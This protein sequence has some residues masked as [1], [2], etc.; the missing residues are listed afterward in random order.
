MSEPDPHHVYSRRCDARR[1]EAK[2]HLKRARR[3]SNTRLAVFGLGMV[4][5]WMVW[6]AKTLSAW[7]MVP[8]LV[9]F[10]FLMLLHDRTLQAVRR[11]QRGASLYEKG[12][13]RLEDRWAG[14]GNLGLQFL[15]ESHPYARDM[16]LFGAGSLFEL[17]CSTRTVWGAKTLAEWLLTPASLDA[18]RA[19]QAAVAELRPRLELREEIAVLD[20]DISSEVD[21][22]AL[23]RWAGSPPV[24][25][26]SWVPVVAFVLGVA[27]V[28]VIAGLL[29]STFGRLPVLVVLAVESGLAMWWRLRVREV[30]FS[31]ERPG[32]ELALLA[33]L[34]RR[35]ENEPFQSP[36][37]VEIQKS[38]ESEGVTASQQIARLGRLI[39]LLDARRNQLFAPLAALLMWGTQVAFALERWR[40]KSGAGVANILVS[41][42]ELEALLALATYSYEHPADPFP[43]LVEK[44]PLFEGEGLGHPLIPK[45]YLVRNDVRLGDGMHLLV[46]SGS[47]MS[48]K[49]TLLRTIGTNSVLA[50]C[51]APVRAKSLRMSRLAVGASIRLLDSLQEGVSRF[52]AEIKRLRQIMDLSKEPLPLVFLLDEILHGT[53]S[54][55]RRI[56]A[57]AVVR[58]LVERGAVGLITTHDL[59]LSRVAETLAAGAA[60]VHFE[61][62]LEDGKMVFDYRLR[63]GV[64]RKSNALDLM[65]S[66]GLEV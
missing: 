41:I 52:Y 49:S 33:K 56:G 58:G 45:K 19:R 42:G 2:R 11:A 8:A 40:R 22:D 38:L 39:D 47:N 65:R 36:R 5:A 34:L 59:A 24:L 3:I 48:G 55:D 1:A 60:N 46:V 30:I 23:A 64:V 26:S 21:P 9:L 12:L 35:F 28:T 62:H 29:S 20:E 14:N 6:E 15:D 32:R 7:W 16:D 37:L 51:G 54:H 4:L 25:G 13:A 57:E 63:S 18:I 27:A 44:G 61:D 31:V 10:G 50:L 66:I 17:L 53:N 43:D